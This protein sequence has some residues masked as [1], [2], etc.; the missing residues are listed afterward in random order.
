MR[1][2]TLT[3]SGAIGGGSALTKGGAGT[4]VLSGNNSFSGA[5]NVLSGTLSTPTI[6]S[7]G[8]CRPPG[9]GDCAGDVG[10]QRL[11]CHVSLH[12]LDWEH[13]PRL[14]LWPEAV[15]WSSRPAS[16]HSAGVI[17][18]NGSLTQV[19]GRRVP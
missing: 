17:D 12:Q 18:G 14:L 5:I 6:N 3:L 8:K 11:P 9:H 2:T 1:A 19:G 4:L 16:L 15:E 7:P 13:Q 10:E